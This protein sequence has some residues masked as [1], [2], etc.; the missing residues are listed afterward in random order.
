MLLYNTVELATTQVI[1][2]C[3]TSAA[4]DDSQQR[5]HISLQS[6]RNAI[7]VDIVSRRRAMS[8]SDDSLRIEQIYLFSA[9][10]DCC[11]ALV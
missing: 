6:R 9:G 4:T 5:Q 2:G 3:N 7:L 11:G 1:Q 10:S 8:R